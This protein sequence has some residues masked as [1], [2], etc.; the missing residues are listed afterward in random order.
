MLIDDLKLDSPKAIIDLLDALYRSAAFCYWL[1]TCGGL[2]GL[3]DGG[4]G[5][6]SGHAI[7]EDLNVARTAQ[8]LERL[9]SALLCTVFRS[10]GIIKA[11]RNIKDPA[12]L[13]HDDCICFY[14]DE[15]FLKPKNIKN[16]LKRISI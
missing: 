12:T 11:L 2:D 8:D 4:N 13:M 6:W 10:S 5:D 16:K 7:M 14:E 3:I 15:D 9:A 1:D